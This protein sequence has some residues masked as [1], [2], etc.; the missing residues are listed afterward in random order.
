MA[1][2]RR[3]ILG[4]AIVAS[5]CSAF[6]T[7]PPSQRCTS[8]RVQP[9]IDTAITAALVA[10]AVIAAVDRDCGPDSCGHTFDPTALYVV[11]ALPFA[12]AAVY[13]FSTASSCRAVKTSAVRR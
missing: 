3:F 1:D 4:A 7:R 5:G 12:I 9:I 11:G 13:G 6:M 10:G 2:V 8:S